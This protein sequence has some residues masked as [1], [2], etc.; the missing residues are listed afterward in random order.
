MNPIER[1][2]E[3]FRHFPGIGERQAKRFVYYLLTRDQSALHTLSETIKELKSTT[4]SCALCARFFEVKHEAKTVCNI[5]AN[6]KRDTKTLLIVPKD[7]DLE[8]VEKSKAYNGLYFVLGGTIPLLDKEPERRIRQVKLLERVTAKPEFT[9]T[10]II[11]G[12]SVNAEG[13]YTAGYITDLI[14]D[15]L[16]RKSLA[17]IQ[18]SILGRGLSTGTELEYSDKDTLSNA[19]KTRQAR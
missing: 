19:L 8:V 7:Q 13:E 16:K 5:C 14:K 9:P 4:A 1:L 2:T 15:E 6:A 12:T 11:I 3:I 18:I 17:D 10:E